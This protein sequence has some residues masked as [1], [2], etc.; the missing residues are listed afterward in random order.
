VVRWR[1][2][3]SLAVQE[4]LPFQVGQHVSSRRKGL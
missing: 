1:A 3:G 2:H 4:R